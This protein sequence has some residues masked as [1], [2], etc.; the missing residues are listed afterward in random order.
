MRVLCRISWLPTHQVPIFS[1]VFWR[2]LKNNS[3]A[4]FALLS[5]SFYNV[6]RQRMDPQLLH[7]KVRQMKTNTGV[8]VVFKTKRELKC[9][10]SGNIVCL[11]SLIFDVTIDNP[12]FD[13]VK[14]LR[15]CV[16]KAGKT[17]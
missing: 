7:Q 3:F 15:L 8:F 11:L 5:E 1:F 10:F 17:Q 13:V 6:S 9:Q 2:F 14:R 12:F 16:F 4:L